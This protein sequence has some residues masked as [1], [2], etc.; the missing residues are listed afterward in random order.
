[1]AKKTL[2]QQ[3]LEENGFTWE[4]VRKKKMR[5]PTPKK[6]DAKASAP[7]SIRERRVKNASVESV[8]AFVERN[9]R[10]DA[11]GCIFVPGAVKGVTASVVYC[12]K[13]MTAARYMCLLTH[14][15]PKY[16]GAVSRHLCG[17][18]HLSCVN[19]RH[20]VWGDASD[21]ASDAQRHRTVGEN[22]TDRINSV[23]R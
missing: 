21:N 10:A 11:D 12:D 5:P 17:N 20:I 13:Q 8:K 4:G 7:R 9:R 15:A 18:G 2:A 14:G 19:P 3:W 1:M 16:E 22:V 6:R 23:T